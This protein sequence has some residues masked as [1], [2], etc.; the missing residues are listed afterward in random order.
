MVGW[1]FSLTRGYIEN[2]LLVPPMA[3]DLKHHTDFGSWLEGLLH[4]AGQN[5]VTTAALDAF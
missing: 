2:P 4:S 5:A 3:F 1:C